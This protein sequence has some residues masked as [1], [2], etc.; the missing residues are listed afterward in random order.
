MAGTHRRKSLIGGVIQATLYIVFAIGVSIPPLIYSYNELER[1][2]IGQELLFD[3][4]SAKLKTSGGGQYWGGFY[5]AQFVPN[6]GRVLV[7][8]QADYSFYGD[9]PFFNHID[10][11]LLP[12]YSMSNKA[13][14]FSFLRELDISHILVPNYPVPS[15]YN[16]VLSSI[17]ADSS[18]ASLIQ[19]YK[20]Y[21]LYEI[22]S[23]RLADHCPGRKVIFK[24]AFD[25]DSLGWTVWDDKREYSAQSTLASSQQ[26]GASVVKNSLL[27]YSSI[28]ARL[29]TGRGPIEVGPRDSFAGYDLRLKSRTRYRIEAHVSGKGRYD[30]DIV[31]Y[32]GEGKNQVSSVWHGVLGD[33]TQVAAS[34]FDTSEGGDENIQFRVLFRLLSPGELKVSYI[35]VE[36]VCLD[37]NNP[38][39]AGQNLAS[40]FGWYAEA[41]GID[42]EVI[43]WGVFAR[44]DGVGNALS[45]SQ[46]G[47]KDVVLGT[48]PIRVRASSHVYKLKGH[49]KGKGTVVVTQSTSCGVESK[50]MF[51][52]PKYEKFELTFQHEN[53]CQLAQEWDV[54]RLSFTL[55]A[56]YRFVGRPEQYAELEV[57]DIS[58]SQE[59]DSDSTFIVFSQDF[60]ELTGE[61]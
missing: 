45:I 19:R 47:G 6:N 7:F 34:V 41:K 12:L 55:K 61:L 4:D 33:E 35:V 59:A 43:H 9:R 58:L 49:I 18:F 51:L 26:N 56:D 32:L 53:R 24:E 15:I 60:D 16:S 31:E 10:P 3:S 5:L 39:R 29:Y 40:G 52:S 1:Y 50:T 25:G 54:I 22:R 36:E 38:L 13:E 46:E 57:D 28:E 14:A 44:S 20:G 11:K 48:D 8:R 42:K 21:A 37:D 30:M 17:L 2:G 23:S 27:S